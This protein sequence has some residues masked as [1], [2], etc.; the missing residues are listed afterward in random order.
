MRAEG[1]DHALVICEYSPKT[2]GTQP[3]EDLLPL[4]AVTTLA[5]SR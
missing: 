3:A 2:T 5:G 1:V 4:T